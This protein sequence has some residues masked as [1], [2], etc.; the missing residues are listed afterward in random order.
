MHSRERLSAAPIRV[1]VI[2]DSSF[3]RNALAKRIGSDARFKVID[4]AEN[5]LQGVEKALR[6]RPDVITLDVEM[7]VMNGIDALKQIVAQTS[8]PVVML[9]AVTEAGAKITLEALEIGAV[10]FIPKAKGAQLIHETLFAAVGANVKARQTRAAPLQAV[11]TPP[12]PRVPVESNKRVQAKIVMIGSSTGGPQALAQVIKQFPATLPV[13][14]VV[15]QHMP[16]QF[17]AALAKRLDDTC[18]IKV[19]EA[20]NGDALQNGVVYIAPGG[21]H[22]RV[23]SK[24]LDV[25]PDKGDNLYHPSV[26]ILAQSVMAT[27]GKNVLGVML[28]GMG[29]DGAREFTKLKQAGAYNLSQDQASCVVYGMPKSLVDAGGANEVLPLDQIGLRVRALLGC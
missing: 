8:I 22:L 28:T 27:F 16:P 11:T 9:S 2:E 4:T 10:D 23:T 26:D 21:M 24:G 3:M 7:P 6:L 12:P 1:L 15:A 18:A 13:P 5:G 17:T 29:S 14:V 20:K 19:V 25:S